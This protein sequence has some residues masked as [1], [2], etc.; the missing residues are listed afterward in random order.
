MMRF[1]K[2]VETYFW[3]SLFTEYSWCNRDVI[4]NAIFAKR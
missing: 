2:D 4:E 1:T 3:N